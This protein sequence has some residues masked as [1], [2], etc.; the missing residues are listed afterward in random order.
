MLF[1][2]TTKKPMYVNILQDCV[3][4]IESFVQPDGKFIKNYNKKYGSTKG[5]NFLDWSKTCY[6]ILIL[7][8]KSRLNF[9]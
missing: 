7:V 1:N 9:S 6:K 8:N 4:H 3:N 2:Q 5:G